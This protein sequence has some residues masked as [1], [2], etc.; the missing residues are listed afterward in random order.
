MDEA[1]VIDP[2]IAELQIVLWRSMPND[3]L[4][5]MYRRLEEWHAEHPRRGGNPARDAHRQTVVAADLRAG[6][7]QKEVAERLTVPLRQVQRDVAVI[8]T[9]YADAGLVRKTDGVPVR[10][11]RSEARDEISD[12]FVAVKPGRVGFS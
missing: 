4:G 1:M 2:G 10:T 5:A 12:A 6:Y 7:S 8:R 11:A 3:G 9:V